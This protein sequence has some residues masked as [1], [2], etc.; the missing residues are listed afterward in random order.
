[1]KS[2]GR[3][4]IS[5]E[6][7]RA[8]IECLRS[9][10]LTQGPKVKELESNVA[11]FCGADYA[12]AVNSATSA[13]HIACLALGLKS[14]DT[15]W[16]SANTFVASANCARM[17]GADVDFVDIDPD[18]G[19]MCV[20]ALAHKLADAKASSTL[21]KVIIPV[22]FS[23]Q[24]CDMK[25]IAELV[26]P[27]GIK[28]IEDASH[29]LGGQY[30]GK[31]VGYCEYSDISVFSFHPVKMI[32]TAEGGMAL[33]QNKQLADTMRLYSSHGIRKVENDPSMPPWYYEQHLLGFNYRMSDLNAALGVSQLK[34]LSA[35]VTK[36]N[37]LARYY[38]AC[39]A[40][41]DVQPL[42]QKVDGVS[43]YHLY[44]IKVDPSKRLTVFIKLRE[45]GVG[46][47]VHYIPVYQ[48]PYYQALGF[49][50]LPNTQSYYSQCI[51]LPLYPTLS[52]EEQD[53]VVHLVRQALEQS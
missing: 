47:Q 14:G 28:I 43:S 13:L 38:D 46:V 49:K 33:T 37:E 48:Q 21:P 20:E 9:D 1:M 44:V 7:E 22:H 39:F 17:C 45:L 36:R 16:T 24:S 26:A 18:T 4:T 11:A 31:P 23:G 42:V 32:T 25:R 51:S 5:A 27:F 52:I 50:P 8:I 6:D 10:F 29:A 12:V 15:V 19:N 34:N 3:Q 2:Y 53:S 40:G 35:W 30:Q 41:T